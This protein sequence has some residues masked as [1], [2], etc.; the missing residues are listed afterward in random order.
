MELIDS[1]S[2]K[3]AAIHTV[4][5]LVTGRNECLELRSGLPQAFIRA[6]SG[7]AQVSVIRVS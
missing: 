2:E 5:L 7:K 3:N 4:M 1:M 6:P